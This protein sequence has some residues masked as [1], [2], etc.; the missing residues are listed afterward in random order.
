MDYNPEALFVNKD[1]RITNG[2]KQRKT[3]ESVDKKGWISAIKRRIQ[4]NLKIY[5]KGV[6]KTYI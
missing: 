5:K 4:K 3:I 6:D 1:G 2:K